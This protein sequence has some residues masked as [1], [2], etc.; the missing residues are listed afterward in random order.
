MPFLSNEGLIDR[1]GYDWNAVP[2]EFR[3]GMMSD[4]T[5]ERIISGGLFSLTRA[6]IGDLAVTFN[7]GRV[8]A[9]TLRDWFSG[10]PNCKDSIVFTDRNGSSIVCIILSPIRR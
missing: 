10:M 1:F 6:E 2:V 7:G 5:L 4:H 9:G 8:E 3:Q